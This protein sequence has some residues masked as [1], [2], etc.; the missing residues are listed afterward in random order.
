MVGP[1]PGIG[2]V[3]TPVSARLSSAMV[4]ETLRLVECESPT[5]PPVTTG[6]LLSGAGSTSL[7]C[8]SMLSTESSSYPVIVEPMANPCHVPPAL[9]E[10]ASGVQ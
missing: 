5:S 4:N 7:I 9:E 10:A 2:V 8:Q 6:A 1:V 3:S